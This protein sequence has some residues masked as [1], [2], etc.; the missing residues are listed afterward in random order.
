MND[1]QYVIKIPAGEIYELTF[2]TQQN[3]QNDIHYIGIFINTTVS[4]P[5]KINIGVRLN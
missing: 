3:D 4:R 2:Q 1:E 5:N